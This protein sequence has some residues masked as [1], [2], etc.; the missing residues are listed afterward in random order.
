MEERIL[1]W[2]ATLVWATTQDVADVLGVHRTT[3]LR[4]LNRL[5]NEGL[6]RF[7]IV[8]AP[9]AEMHV[10]LLTSAGV[11]RLFPEEHMHPGWND[12]HVHGPLSEEMETHLHPSYWNSE[13]G[14]QELFTLLEMKR[15]FYPLAIHLFKGDGRQWHPDQAEAHLISFRWLRRNQIFQAVGEYQGN[16]RVFFHWVSLEM[17]DAMLRA[18]WLGRFA[19]LITYVEAD[20]DSVDLYLPP[21]P[22]LLRASGNV[23]LAED[24]GAYSVVLRNLAALSAGRPSP[25]FVTCS[26]DA[27]LQHREGMVMP[28]MDNASNPHVDLAVGEP[29]NLCPPTTEDEQLDQGDHHGE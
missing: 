18:R 21:E 2:L 13:V 22:S 26:A 24:S 27:S 9:P 10:W 19:N 5:R 12:S 17:S 29:E 25:W 23:I 6:V 11:W 15:Q 20:D 1:E 7:R 4:W 16:L 28:S 3:A 14:A 8:G